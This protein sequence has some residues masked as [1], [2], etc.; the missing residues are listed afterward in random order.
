MSRV[1]YNEGR[2]VGLSAYE[3]FVREAY[4]IDPDVTPPTELAWLI[5]S[6]T[7]GS[8]MLL[9]L[10]PDNSVGSHYVEIDFPQNSNLWAC[11]TIIGSLFIGTGAASSDSANGWCSKVISYG[12]LIA[13]RADSSPS[14]DGTTIP[15]TNPAVTLTDYTK[16]EI[17]EY[18]KIVDGIVIQPG[19]WSDNASTP[20]QKNLVP[21]ATEPPKVRILLSDSLSERIFILLTGFTDRRVLSAIMDYSTQGNNPQDG[22]FLGPASYPWANKIVFTSPNVSNQEVSVDVVDLA[23]I[24]VY[25]TKYLWP[26]Q[27]PPEGSTTV[28]DALKNVKKLTGVQ[29]VSGYVSQ[30]FV[31]TYC[32][33]HADANAAGADG[34]IS[35][36]LEVQLKYV[37]QLEA[38]GIA[39]DYKYCFIYTRDQLTASSQDGAFWPVRIS[40]RR[41]LFTTFATPPDINTTRGFNFSGS[42]Y[43]DGSVTVPAVST[44]MMGSYWNPQGVVE[45]DTTVSQVINGVTVFTN[46]PVQH[47]AIPEYDLF[48]QRYCGV[49]KPPAAYGDDFLSWLSGTPIKN[50]LNASDSTVSESILTAMGVHTSYWN[51]DAESFLQYMATGRDMT[52]SID[53][54]YATATTTDSFYI[55]SRADIEDIALNGLSTKNAAVTMK[56]SF[57]VA[58]FFKPAK[59]RFY[60]TG[61]GTPEITDLVI[62]PAYHIWGADTKVDSENITALSLTDNFGGLLPMQGTKGDISGDKINWDMIITALSQN[63]SI[64]IL[65]GAKVRTNYVQLGNGLRL[66]IS[67][68][69]PDDTDVPE[70]SVGLGWNGIKIYTSGAW[71]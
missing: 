37:K 35:S 54:D 14:A 42:S 33:S 20:P 64:D 56:A 1:L 6:L 10:V 7:N 15:P 46:H 41:I 4:G 59:A 31:N 48:S 50:V 19:T 69:A 26:F 16:R 61:T 52:K 30:E 65:N 53:T 23:N 51:L 49:P 63:K 3:L 28:T 25:N 40:D 22:D 17:Q 70:G 12:P 8:S 45:S 38:M 43:T 29:V 39:D 58:D 18:A 57:S 60:S 71:T 44:D 24:Y 47:W 21:D 13:N 67:S 55:Y 34:K 66:Y 68:T 27:N 36:S 11:D 9:Q 62:D 5:A 2:V 32:V